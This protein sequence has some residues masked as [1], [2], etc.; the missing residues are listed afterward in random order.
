LYFSPSVIRVIE[1]EEIGG[2]L[3]TFRG[4]K[5]HEYAYPVLMGIPEGKMPLGRPR[6]GWQVILK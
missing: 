5:V 2:A 6:H 4:E 3:G 1:G